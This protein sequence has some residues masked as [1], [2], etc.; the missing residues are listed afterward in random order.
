MANV[1]MWT[2]K[3]GNK[4]PMS[5]IQERDVDTQKELKRLRSLKECRNHLCADCGSSDNSWASV[6]HGVFV[7]IVCSD[8]HRSVGTHITKMKGCSGT[9][10]WGPDEIEKM[11]TVGNYRADEIYGVKKVSPDAS[12]EEKQRFLMDKY[13]NCLSSNVVAAVAPTSLPLAAAR[14]ASRSGS[15]EALPATTPMV[16]VKKNLPT[17]HGGA[18]KMEM[19]GMQHA[20]V[21][22]AAWPQRA[23][24]TVP[25]ATVSGSKV[26]RVSDIPDSWF[27]DLFGEDNDS[28]APRLLPEKTINQTLGS[29]PQPAADGGDDLEAFLNNAF[30]T[31]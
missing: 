31:F 24:S 13:V 19:Q 5:W 9:Y 4:Y 16:V 26:A 20:P 3:L 22:A 11:Q 29:F 17:P 7:C 27:D 8:V 28:A 14:A 30:G 25:R 2:S 6:T 10:L 23:S 1:T 21:A 12:K 18:K 15:K